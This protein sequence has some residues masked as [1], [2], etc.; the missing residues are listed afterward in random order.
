MIRLAAIL[1]WL[2]LAALAALPGSAAAS[3]KPRDLWA[4]INVCDSAS[5]PNRVGVRAQMPGDGTRER[6]YMRFTAQF[7]SGQ[8]WKQVSGQGMSRWVY[9]GSALFKNQ[10][11]GWTFSFQKPAAGSS[12]TVRGLVDFQWRKRRGG[13]WVVVRRARAASTAGH[14]SAT[15]EPT[16]F[17]AAHCTLAQP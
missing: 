10:E 2:S 7:L 1:G 5:T 3:A 16:G 13:R 14:S 12:Y 9:A 4:T 8:T 17:S 11:S 6:M 15:A